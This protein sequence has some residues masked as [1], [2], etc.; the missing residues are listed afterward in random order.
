MSFSSKF[1][2]LFSKEGL[3]DL[4]SSLKSAYPKISLG[5]LIVYVCLSIIAIIAFLVRILP[6]QWGAYLSEF[7]PYYHY[8]VTEYVVKNFQYAF[9]NAPIPGTGASFW[10][11]VSYQFWYPGGRNIWATT[12]PGLPFSGAIFYFI[13]SFL[14]FHVS[15]EEALI[16]FP[17]VM[18]AITCIPL[19]FFAKDIGGKEVGLLSALILSLNIA[20]ISRTYLGFFKHETIGI[21]ALILIALFYLRAIEPEKSLSKCIYYSIAAGLVL[22]YLDISWT[23]F[24]YSMD[25]IAIF[26]VALIFLRRYRPNILISFSITMGISL[27]VASQVPRPGMGVLTY[28]G[29]LPVYGALGLL[30]LSE[31]FMHA[32]TL[33]MKVVA[34]AFS[35]VSVLGLVFVLFKTRLFGAI[36]GKLLS[37]VNPILR[38]QMPIIE[39]VA[40]HQPATWASMYYEFGF[41]SIFA[42]I[43]F[44]F[45]FK[46]PNNKN[47]YLILFGVTALYFATSYDRL[48]LILAPAFAVL[49]SLAVVEMAKPFVDIIRGVSLFPKRK[50]RSA[51]HVSVEFGA[52]TVILLFL[53]V[54]STVVQGVS[55]AYQ[56]VTIAS[57]T[58]PTRAY[59]GDWLEACAWLHDNTPQNSVV[60]C[61]WDYGYYVTVLGNRTTLADNATLNTTQIANIGLIYMS[62]ESV[63]L[64]I[65]KRY[66]TSYILVFTT[67][68]LYISQQS[69]IFYGDEVKWTWMAEIA[70][71]NVTRLQDTTLSQNLGLTSYGLY[72]PQNWTVFTELTLYGVLGN[73]MTTYGAIPPS[74]HFS[75][76]YTSSNNLIFIYKINY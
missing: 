7:D 35:V 61:W 20:Y 12:P 72:L 67:L 3:K 18:G 33:K 40:E 34:M 30:V 58:I 16:F 27:L 52:I 13:L 45:A 65:L 36:G 37:V 1:R 28:S 50:A 15:V 23:A 73:Q 42:L 46:K 29:T 22:A 21:F 59:V 48:D 26:V 39:S 60:C 38:L 11:W 56:P 24:Y 49:S 25:L 4:F 54:F 6:L 5:S 17:P 32:R 51:T 44:Y 9:T 75:L 74:S 41:L 63:A 57:S 53:L 8:F 64:P 43:G 55:S 47:I 31:I 66:N 62:N 14:G 76:V 69:P 68:S 19:Y 2:K 70:G 71:L 10:N